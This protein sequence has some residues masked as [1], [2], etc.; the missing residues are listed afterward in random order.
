MERIWIFD[1]DSTIIDTEALDVLVEIIE[2]EEPSFCYERNLKQEIDRITKA[3]M[4]GE[5]SFDIALQQRLDLLSIKPEWIKV[6][7]QLLLKRIG[8]SFLQHAAWLQSN[9]HRIYVIS[10]GFEEYIVPVIEQLGLKTSHVIANKFLLTENGTYTVDT[11]KPLSK[12]MGKVKAL[13][14]MNLGGVLC[15]VGDGYTDYETKLYNAVSHFYLYAEHVN[16]SHIIT[17]SDQVVFSLS[18]IIALDNG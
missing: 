7:S 14:A 17:D 2:K 11:A 4:N 15:M 16:R 8:A 5:L 1:F 13:N 6:L 9:K 12:A 3:A 10:G 18:E